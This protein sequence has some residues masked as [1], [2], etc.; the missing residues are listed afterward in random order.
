MERPE[1]S[2]AKLL[3]W[4]RIGEGMQTSSQSLASSQRDVSL[5]L[6]YAGRHLSVPLKKAVIMR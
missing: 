3:Y 1:I 6:N 2:E 4:A 5:L